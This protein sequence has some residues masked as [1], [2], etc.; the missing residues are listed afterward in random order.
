MGQWHKTSTNE[1]KATKKLKLNDSLFGFTDTQT[2]VSY[3]G[4]KK[5]N[6]V[7][8][9]SMHLQPSSFWQKETTNG[10][11]LLRNQRGVDTMDQMCLNY[12]TRVRQRDGS[13]LTK[14]QWRPVSASKL[15]FPDVYLLSIIHIGRS[16][17]RSVAKV[18]M[19]FQILRQISPSPFLIP[20]KF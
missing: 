11:R 16:F 10:L 19:R 18:L 17:M 9:S 12:T 5:K 7:L 1:V 3:Q 13:C 8:L 15:K 14:A 6:V 2:M 20:L 4:K